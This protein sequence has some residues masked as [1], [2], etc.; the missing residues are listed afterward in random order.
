MD[1]D[2][3][4]ESMELGKSFQS[5]SLGAKVDTAVKHNLSIPQVLSMDNHQ[6]GQLDLDSPEKWNPLTRDF[7]GSTPEIA[8]IYAKP[9]QVKALDKFARTADDY[10]Y[11]KTVSNTS[12]VIQRDSLYGNHFVAQDENYRKTIKSLGWESH[13]LYYTNIHDPQKRRFVRPVIRNSGWHKGLWGV[14]EKSKTDHTIEDAKRKFQEM[15]FTE[16]SSAESNSFKAV[17]DMFKSARKKLQFVSYLDEIGPEWRGMDEG[18]IKASINKFSEKY[19]IDMS[20][21]SPADFKARES[22]WLDTPKA[23]LNNFPGVGQLNKQLE[24]LDH[25]HS[26]VTS[27]DVKASQELVDAWLADAIGKTGMSGVKD[28]IAQSAPYMMHFLIGSGFASAGK[29]FAVS[30]LKNPDNINKFVRGTVGALGAST[31]LTATSFSNQI[32]RDIEAEKTYATFD[33]KGNYTVKNSELSD[34]DLFFKHSLLTW[35]SVTSEY[36]GGALKHI[37]FVGKFLSRGVAKAASGKGIVSRTINAASKLGRRTQMNVAFDGPFGE[38]FEEGIDQAGRFFLTKA[39]QAMSVDF[40]ESI[41]TDNLFMDKKEFTTTAGVIGLQSALFGLPNGA[42]RLASLRSLKAK[43][44][45]LRSMYQSLQETPEL[46][47]SKQAMK[48]F[49]IGGIGNAV[50][51]V[52]ARNLEAAFQENHSEISIKDALGLDQTTDELIKS[53]AAVNGSVYLEADKL[54]VDSANSEVFDTVMNLSEDVP[55]GV[56]LQRFEETAKQLQEVSKEVKAT[57]KEMEANEA[58]YVDKLD[59]YTGTVKEHDNFAP[60]ESRV[61]IKLFDTMVRTLAERSNVAPIDIINNLDVKNMSYKDFENAS[62]NRGAF[63]TNG[64]GGNVIALFEGAKL[65][66]FSHETYHFLRNSMRELAKAGL[67]ENSQFLN[68]IDYLDNYENGNEELGAKAFEKYL[69][70]GKAPNSK[71][72]NMFES[73]R[74]F[75]T[76]IYAFITSNDPYFA[77]VEVNEELRGVFDRL[78][79]SEAQADDVIKDEQFF[80][81]LNYYHLHGLGAKDKKGLS[82]ILNNQKDAVLNDIEKQK[83]KE[84]PAVRKAAKAEAKATMKEMPVYDV[85][86]DIKKDG[87]LK[88]TDVQSLMLSVDKMHR[89]VAKG[90]VAPTRA[91]KPV[92]SGLTRQEA[93]KKRWAA[94]YE[95][96]RM[97]NLIAWGAV[98]MKEHYDNG[99][100]PDGKLDE[101]DFGTFFNKNGYIIDSY[102]QELSDIVGY[103]VTEEVLIEALKRQSIP[104]FYKKYSKMASEEHAYWENLAAEEHEHDEY[105]FKPE[106]LSILAGKHGY[107]S[108]RDMIEDLVEHPVPHFFEKQFVA[109]RMQE[110]EEHFAESAYIVAT[111]NAIDQLEDMVK[112]L[113]AK[114]G[115]VKN[116]HK[117]V[118]VLRSEVNE[119]L[120]TQNVKQI[121]DTTRPLDSIRNNS[122][123]A[124]LAMQK[125]QWGKA[126]ELVQSVRY[127]IEELKQKKQKVETIKK[128]I[129]TVKRLAKY[130]PGKK[131]KS[132]IWGASL[133]HIQNIAHQ[134]GIVDF[135]ARGNTS[136]TLDA[137]FEQFGYE[138]DLPEIKQYKDLTYNEFADLANTLDFLNIIGSGIVQRA[139]AELNEQRIK[140]TETARKLLAKAPKVKVH[141]KNKI[142]KIMIDCYGMRYI[143]KNTLALCRQMD[144]YVNALGNKESGF[145]EKKFYEQISNASSNEAQLIFTAQEMALPAIVHL[146]A[147]KKKFTAGFIEK[148]DLPPV[149]SKIQRMSSKQWDFEM[150]LSVILNLG[151]Q[152]NYQKLQDGYAIHNAEGK[153]IGSEL[154]PEEINKIAALFSTNEDWDAIELLWKSIESILPA[155]RAAHLATTY[156]ELKEVPKRAFE[157]VVKDEHGES[158]RVIDGGY[159]HI[160]YDYNLDDSD[161]KKSFFEKT[162]NVIGL[163]GPGAGDT[164]ERVDHTGRPIKL[165][166]SVFERQL[167]D[168]AHSAAFR[169]VTRDLDGI[170]KDGELHTRMR[171][172]LGD[173]GAKAFDELV[174]TAVNPQQKDFPLLKALDAIVT[175]KALWFNITSALMQHAGVSQGITTIGKENFVRAQINFYKKPKEIMEFIVNKSIFMRDRQKGADFDL[176]RESKGLRLSTVEQ[177]IDSMR[178]VGFIGIRIMDGLASFPMWFEAYNQ[179]LEAG[180]SDLNAVSFADRLIAETQGTGRNIDKV[181]GQHIAGIKHLLK[182]F[183]AVSAFSNRQSTVYKGWKAGTVSNAEY[184]DFVLGEL[185]APALYSGMLRLLGSGSL[186]GYVLA[187]I[188][189]DDDE[190]DEKQNKVLREYIAETLAFGVQGVPLVR[191]IVDQGVS[192]IMG[193]AVYAKGNVPVLRPWVDVLSMVGKAGKAINSTGTGDKDAAKHWGSAID[194]AVTIGADA[195][196]IPLVT[197]AKRVNRAYK[198]S[199]LND[200]D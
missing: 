101:G 117:S 153:V 130:N 74:K 178:Q 88:N 187:G 96:L 197:A 145:F 40:L 113:G 29:N 18:V 83:A 162:R 109:Q 66:T 44:M 184:S 105:L 34:I 115:G 3:I 15:Q 14:S 121:M 36:S 171:E 102:A 122:R 127:Q 164:K 39:G 54:L 10:K 138:G 103:E 7:I 112:V 116:Y 49:V 155:K 8:A 182:F 152:D 1:N 149:P 13:G 80:K 140:D 198:K 61:G 46:M 35:M 181:W 163:Q 159:Y 118:K 64:N 60:S 190:F 196:R 132:K 167:Y 154:G 5:D 86:K 124:M 70:S 25:I 12:S 120:N 50:L 108:I 99:I 195:T 23:I 95:W 158:Q 148:A 125:K 192:S 174:K 26:V 156:T 94:F 134:Y 78:I 126:F 98:V 189:G 169:E 72:K 193:T 173:Q 146:N 47:Q 28:G 137:V 2:K 55:G 110:F 100:D 24:A 41:N 62:G 180:K 48:G 38:M 63:A 177:K 79:T 57:V 170:M 84:R 150:L 97:N 30:L 157:V 76:K 31:A 69:Q 4:I 65:D 59:A 172:T 107:D 194:A 45:T 19:N 175:A 151:T 68:D 16:I 82:K 37:P 87:A 43:E 93:S 176:R 20:D 160:D 166:F 179:Q 17:S 73:F 188:Y 56:T 141:S 32:G 129:A 185:V 75:L 85:W 168:S 165:S 161:R 136:I 92:L 128:T 42:A 51:T 142:E 91:V 90:A 191:D 21:L 186:L 71:L 6:V 111:N 53:Q 200:D 119:K 11:F 133:F 139:E 67:I 199:R 52:N 131:N 144:R 135:P 89:L 77:G 81:M 33:A 106:P 183:S 104:S 9:K 147:L 58:A 123:D 143:G 27:N 22:S 114:A